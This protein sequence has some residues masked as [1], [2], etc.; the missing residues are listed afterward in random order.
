VRFEK[1]LPIESK[2]F[3]VKE[4][5]AKRAKE[6]RKAKSQEISHIPLF[7]LFAPFY[8]FCFRFQRAIL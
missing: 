7:A 3:T 2:G 8:P 1:P 4:E 5:E 6:T